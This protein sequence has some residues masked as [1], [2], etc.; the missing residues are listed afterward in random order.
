MSAVLSKRRVVLS[1][2]GLVLCFAAA[3]LVYN[4][5]RF[6][7]WAIVPSQ[8]GF[9]AAFAAAA[10]VTATIRYKRVAR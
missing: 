3:L 7:L 1:V 10:V 5:M 6:G 2:I 4:G 8:Y 9:I